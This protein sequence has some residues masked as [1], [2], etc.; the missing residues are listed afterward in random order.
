[1][2]KTFVKKKIN[3]SGPLSN[4]SITINSDDEDDKRKK[5]N[6]GSNIQIAIDPSDKYDKRKKVNSG[7]SNKFIAIG[8]DDEDDHKRKKIHKKKVYKK[9]S[10]KKQ[11]IRSRSTSRSSS[12][13]NLDDDHPSRKVIYL[14][15][16]D[17]PKILR[18]S[19]RVSQLFYF[20]SFLFND[21]T[22]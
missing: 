5:D 3:S 11:K 4:Y 6:S 21:L 18:D 2:T 9:K 14:H 1:M 15:S 13:F 10:K 20:V 16:A 17:M 7:P 22:I 12:K 8:F 19:L